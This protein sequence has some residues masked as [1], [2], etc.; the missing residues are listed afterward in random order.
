MPVTVSQNDDYWTGT[1]NSAGEITMQQ[2]ST[3]LTK[4]VKEKLGMAWMTQLPENG[5]LQFYDILN[6]ADHE[7]L[8]HQDIDFS[9]LLQGLSDYPSINM[10]LPFCLKGSTDKADAYSGWQS[11]VKVKEWE[12]NAQCV[13]LHAALCES[14]DQQN[15]AACNAAAKGTCVWTK[16]VDVS[17]VKTT[18][19]LHTKHLSC[20]SAC[21]RR[22]SKYLS[23]IMSIF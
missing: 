15:E 16:K 19:P 2:I 8:I 12:S 4:Q 9:P 22:E 18:F 17:S 6:A 11:Y 1:V 7:N 23:S 5:K 14:E 13:K 21:S 10:R 20:K 3:D